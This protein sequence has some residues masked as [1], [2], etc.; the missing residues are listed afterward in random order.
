MSEN[1]LTFKELRR[2]TDIVPGSPGAARYENRSSASTSPGDS[3]GVVIQM[4]ELLDKTAIGHTAATTK[5]PFGN[6]IAFR[7]FNSASSKEKVAKV[8]A[9]EQQQPSPLPQ[10]SALAPTPKEWATTP[11]PPPLLKPKVNGSG[12]TPK[13]ILG[14]VSVTAVIGF[15]FLSQNSEDSKIAAVSNVKPIDPTSSKEELAKEQA[16][17]SVPSQAQ[18]PEIVNRQS[19]EQSKL[20]DTSRKRDLTSAEPEPAAKTSSGPRVNAEYLLQ[21]AEKNQW[22]D[23]QAGIASLL[24][25]EKPTRGDRQK[26]R[27]LYE[28]GLQVRFENPRQALELVRAAAS[29][30]PA[31]AEIA[32]T[33]GLLMREAGVFRGSK[34]HLMSVLTIWPDRSTAWVNLAETLSRLNQYDGSVS[35]LVA[36][37]KV[38]R[39]PENTMSSYRRIEADVNADA[40]FRENV[41]KAIQA[42][43]NRR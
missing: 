15:M 35:A 1:L 2:L 39:N 3:N 27:R 20:T 26:A 9:T 25:R 38:S 19:D 37:H 17:V 16:P 32:D 23:F 11:T 4:K 13:V 29:T 5:A 30:D 6:V 8:M 24:E 40:Y 34:E 7:D 10:E 43:E 36:G 31:D 12:M 21:A 28:N 42:I 18:N 14:L 33:L 22:A 41:R